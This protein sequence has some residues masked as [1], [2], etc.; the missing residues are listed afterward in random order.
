MPTELHT[1]STAGSITETDA[2]MLM[3]VEEAWFKT[4]RAHFSD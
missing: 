1:V 2:P 3:I 4:A